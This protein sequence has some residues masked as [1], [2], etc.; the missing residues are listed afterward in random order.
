MNRGSTDV[1][2]TTGDTAAAARGVRRLNT[3]LATWDETDTKDM[4]NEAARW[5][6][7]PLVIKVFIDR[8]AA[9][10]AVLDKSCQL[11]ADKETMDALMLIISVMGLA[12][13]NGKP[14]E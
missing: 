3:L 13:L 5:F 11:L 2:L 9:T 1:Y 7:E 12:H 10:A 8:G 6:T 4:R 14:H